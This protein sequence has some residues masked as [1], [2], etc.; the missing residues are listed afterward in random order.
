VHPNDVQR[1]ISVQESGRS[2]GKYVTPGPNAPDSGGGTLGW[3][4]FGTTFIRG[5][6]G[7]HT[8]YDLAAP[9][10]T[11]IYAA[12]SGTVEKV[13]TGTWGGGYGNYIIID[14]GNGLKTLYGHLSTV[15][16]SVGQAVDRG[17]NIAGM[18][19]TGRST[20]PHLHF[21]VIDGGVKRNPSN[22]LK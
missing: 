8:G 20:G 14:H 3:P 4:A 21:E 2:G 13:S 12:E 15:S 17:Q 10:G 5:F 9:K 6:T 22:Y 19:S 18:G 1:D 16:V 11:P 7:S